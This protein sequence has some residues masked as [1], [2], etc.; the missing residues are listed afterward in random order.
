MSKEK[1]HVGDPL[2]GTAAEGD[3]SLEGWGA[4]FRRQREQREEYREKYPQHARLELVVAGQWD[5]I[6]AFFEWARKHP[7][8]ATGVRYGFTDEQARESIAAYLEIDLE[9][10]QR[11]EDAIAAAESAGET[12]DDPT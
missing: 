2:Q 10:Y 9:A 4:V 7:E 5:E 1:H 6:K 12:E 11:E 3:N 8:D